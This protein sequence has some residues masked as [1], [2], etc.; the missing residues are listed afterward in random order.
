MPR[1]TNR[2]FYG[3]FG[4]SALNLSWHPGPSGKRGDLGDYLWVERQ[5]PVQ[6]GGIDGWDTGPARDFFIF[7]P[8]SR[9]KKNLIHLSGNFTHTKNIPLCPM[10]IWTNQSETGIPHFSFP[11][12]NPAIIWKMHHFD[13]D[14][15]RWDS[16]LVKLALGLPYSGGGKHFLNLRDAASYMH[17]V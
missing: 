10:R 4:V 14:R 1:L 12:S 17:G 7:F 15:A 6:E 3:F 5:G 8:R 11:L 16:F 13:T 9:F 2:A